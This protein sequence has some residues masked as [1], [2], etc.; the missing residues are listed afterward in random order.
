ME[1]QSIIH[2]NSLKCYALID[3]GSMVS[4]VSDHVL[5]LM[6]PVPVV[7]NLEEFQL[8]VSVAGGS[9]LPY[10]G[11]VE[12]EVQIPFIQN[13]P[14][15]I[16]MLVVP[17]SD[18]SDR[19]PVIVGTNILRICHEK[20]DCLDEEVK[21]PKQWNTAFLSLHK[22]S[23]VVRSSNR[24]PLTLQPSSYDSFWYG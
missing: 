4:T 24:H 5:K 19:V 17:K 16:P 23:G 22:N 21:I 6:K 10:S 11:Y 3:S 14:I 1:N 18:L 9:K 13:D 12:V 20:L 7:K 15:C 8:S 2:V